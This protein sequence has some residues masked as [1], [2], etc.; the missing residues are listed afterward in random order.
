MQVIGAFIENRVLRRDFEETSG[1]RN[2]K[3]E[4]QQILRGI[5]DMQES[6]RSSAQVLG[7]LKKYRPSVQ[8]RTVTTH[9]AV[10]HISS[11]DGPLRQVN[12]IV[13]VCACVRACVCVCVCVRACVYYFCELL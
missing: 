10:C 9:R 6:L 8:L 3:K 11:L 4:M 2:L 12:S 7:H 13:C 1:A 5:V